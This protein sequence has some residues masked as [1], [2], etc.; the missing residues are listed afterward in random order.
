MKQTTPF[1]FKK[2]EISHSKSSLKVGID[3]TLI[4][5]W[6]SVPLSGE[7]LDIGVGCGLIS[8]MIAQRSENIKVLGVDIHLGSVEE[9]NYN[10]KKS[11]FSERLNAKLID[12]TQMENTDKFDLIVSNPPFFD[13]GII[14]S[15][16]PRISARH[17]C[18]LSLDKLIKKSKELLKEG[19]R[20]SI[21]I[22][23]G[24]K[25]KVLQCAEICGLS[26]ERVTIVRGR[27]DTP[28]RR[29]LIEWKYIPRLNYREKEFNT[30][31]C[32]DLLTLEES[33]GIPTTNYKNLCREFYLK[34]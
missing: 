9:A 22:P 16:D 30:P 19:G 18:S 20:L 34:F 17:Q 24:Q 3:G 33:P 25:E 23:V 8:M 2:F 13:S 15:S 14:Q 1:K 31:Y 32:P 7:V 6:C 10:F 12:F 29:C 28:L 11:P 5:S 27:A 4:G 21:I 26:L